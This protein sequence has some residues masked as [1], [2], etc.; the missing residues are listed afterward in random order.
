VIVQNDGGSNQVGTGCSASR[1]RAVATGTIGCVFGFAAFG[2]FGINDLAVFGT[3]WK[4]PGARRSSDIRGIFWRQILREVVRY[5]FKFGRSSFCAARDHGGDD[6]A[7]TFSGH[8]VA[9]NYG[10]RMARS[11]DPLNGITTRSVG[12][13]GR[14]CENGGRGEECA[15]HKSEPRAKRSINPGSMQMRQTSILHARPRRPLIRC[16]SHD[17]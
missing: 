11:A 15:G 4:G 10:C 12:Q 1:E 13:S 16:R 3:R 8:A 14:L 5:R 2:C 6:L 17:R 9:K 7:P